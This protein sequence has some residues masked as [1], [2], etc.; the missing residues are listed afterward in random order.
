MK[1]EDFTDSESEVFD[2]DI[3]NGDSRNNTAKFKK[4]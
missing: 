2:K 1:D 3:E 4:L